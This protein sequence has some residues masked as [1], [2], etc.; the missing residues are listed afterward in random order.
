MTPRKFLAA[1]RAYD[2][3]S[4]ADQKQVSN[5]AILTAAETKLAELKAHTFVGQSDYSTALFQIK[6]PSAAGQEFIPDFANL[7]KVSAYLQVESNCDITLKITSDITTAEP[8]ELY[9]ET[10]S[11][12]AMTGWA[13]FLLTSPVLL[14]ENQRY[15]FTLSS[16]DGVVMFGKGGTSEGDAAGCCA[17]NGENGWNRF[18]DYQTAFQVEGTE[19]E[20]YQKLIRKIIAL[21]QE[22]SLSDEAT[23]TALLAEYAALSAEDQQK[24]S[25]F[26]RL[27]AASNAIGALKLQARV[28]ALIANI[29]LLPAA[30][31][32]ALS[33]E[34]AVLT[35]R[36]EY[37]ALPDDA[38]QKVDNYETLAAAEAR[39]SQL[40]AEDSGFMALIQKIDAL[41]ETISIFEK[42]FVE[43]LLAQYNALSAEDQAKVTNYDKL[44]AA[45]DRILDIIENIISPDDSPFTYQLDFSTALYLLTGPD[46]AAGQEFVPD[47]TELTAVVAYLDISANN[48]L[49]L[50]I[51]QDTTSDE[52]VLYTED[53]SVEAATTGWYKFELSQSVP[54]TVGEKYDVTITSTDRAVWFGKLSNLTDQLGNFALNYDITNPAYGGWVREM[55]TVAFQAVGKEMAPY[56]L[57]ILK[58]NQLPSE[59]TLKQETTVSKLRNE[60][61]ALSKE[62][63]QKVTNYNLLEAAEARI[64]ELQGIEQEA[65]VAQAIE[66]ISAI[67][68]AITPKSYQAIFTADQAVTN[69]VEKYGKDVTEKITNYAALNQARADYNAFIH[70]Y[71]CGDINADGGINA[72][73]ALLALQHSVHLS[74][75]TGVN[76]YAADVNGDDKIDATDALLILQH[77]VKISDTFPAQP[78]EIILQTS[79]NQALFEAT[80][81]SL[82][83]RTTESGY[84]NT[85]IT[86]AYPGMFVR[87]TYDTDSLS[88]RLR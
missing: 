8:Q 81:Q 55:H 75:I 52:T 47:F 4:I 74:E 10:F 82:I 41:P 62:D 63:Q 7:T 53:F 11:V 71:V 35:L 27:I 72:T 24:V 42:G 61:D 88:C 83:D 69:L 58:I 31:Q 33:D 86:G 43:S 49:S 70:S 18:T 50:T 48:I 6:Q 64:A 9:T 17:L 16:T 2:A 13:S 20:E 40:K 12:E 77:S 38:R 32:L 60:Y 34:A 37:D 44:S 85:S 23:V 66:M 1:R 28:D 45:E 25:N 57:L 46:H 73:D 51:S 39:I 87:D 54:V 29:N 30:D 84:A 59:I 19:I 80:Y 14:N 76:V 56:D 21:P 67:G 65:E 5:Y 68:T 26:E 15:E 22:I 3:L 78:E 36:A 79:E